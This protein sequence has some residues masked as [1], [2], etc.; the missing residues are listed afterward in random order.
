[1]KQH[2]LKEVMLIIWI[3][4]SIAIQPLINNIKDFANNPDIL[5]AT[6]LLNSYMQDDTDL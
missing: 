3:H 4:N 2:T 5:I 6:L 1:M